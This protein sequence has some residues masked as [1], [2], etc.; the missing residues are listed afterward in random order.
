MGEVGSGGQHFVEDGGRGD[1]GG[2]TSG[3]RCSKTEQ[4]HHVA[5]V[6]VE[7]LPFSCLVDTNVWVGRV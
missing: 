6:R 1:E 4:P 3:C 7:R 5:R 2:V